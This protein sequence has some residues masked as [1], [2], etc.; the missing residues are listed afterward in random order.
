MHPVLG[1]LAV[2][3]VAGACAIAL[4]GCH[5]VLR[6]AFGGDRDPPVH[7][8]PAG[9]ARAA[10]TKGR[11]FTGQA[12]GRLAARATIKHGFVKSTMRNARFIGTFSAKLSGAPVAGDDALGPLASAG[13]HGQ[14]TATRNRATGKIVL[15]GMVLA[16]FTEPAAGR[17]CLRLSYKNKRAQNKPLRKPGSSTL[18][19]LGGEGG[20]RT[21][22]GSATVRVKGGTTDKLK[23]SGRVKASRGKPRGFTSACTKLERKFGLQ[24]L[25]G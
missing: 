21:L 12:E 20:A 17:A 9:P 13:W 10:A 11:A 3:V 4:S 19:V 6:L 24:P 2:I 15:T 25:A 8:P 22:A 5:E 1:R 18:K 23:L 16:T 7:A 14:L